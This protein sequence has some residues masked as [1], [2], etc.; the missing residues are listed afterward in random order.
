MFV[1]SD[2]RNNN[3]W[4]TTHK[5]QVIPT[6]K[7]H[8]RELPYFTYQFLQDLMVPLLARCRRIP[9][10]NFRDFFNFNFAIGTCMYIV[11]C[12]FFVTCIFIILVENVLHLT[13]CILVDV[14]IY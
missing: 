13:L 14:P 6:H 7:N 11:T 12:I 10:Y 1:S 3:Y 9:P 5:K 2:R 4:L 8:P